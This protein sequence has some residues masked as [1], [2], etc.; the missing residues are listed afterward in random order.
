M[1]EVVVGGAIRQGDRLLLVQQKK[2]QSTGL[3]GLPGGHVEAN[4]SFEDALRRELLEEVGLV[5]DSHSVLRVDKQGS[6]FEHHTFLCKAHGTVSLQQSELL[7]YGWFTEPDLTNMKP[8]L[9]APFVLDAA[10][11]ALKGA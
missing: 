5:L 9:R 3:W 6:N 2:Q 10:R 7:G 11:A 4:E 1:K 8:Q